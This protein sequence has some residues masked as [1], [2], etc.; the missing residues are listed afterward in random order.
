MNFIVLLVGFN[1]SNVNEN[2]LFLVITHLTPCP[3]FVYIKN[4]IYISQASCKVHKFKGTHPTQFD[5]FTLAIS[6]KATKY[7]YF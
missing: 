2:D 1:I 7:H 6:K 3:S 5:D 4:L